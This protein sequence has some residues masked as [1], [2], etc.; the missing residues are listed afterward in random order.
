MV[1]NKN[2]DAGQRRP[3]TLR[4]RARRQEEVH[5][6]ITKITVDLHE[7]VGPAR[8]TVSEIAKRAGV[9]RATVYNHFPTELELFDACSSHWVEEHPPPNP[10]EWVGI[11]DPGR[12]LETALAALYSYYEEGQDMLENVLRDAPLMPALEE[13]NRRKWWPFI[14]ELVELLTQGWE[15]TEVSDPIAQPGP[16]NVRTSGQHANRPERTLLEASLRVAVDF[17]TWKKL[18]RAGLSNDEASR[19]ATLWIRAC[20]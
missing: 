14:E 3:Y 17:F 2:E 18:A 13:I 8:T 5:R 4:E 11:E 9:Q 6:R 12:R 16:D 7:T 10:A 20:V 15:D 19:L 1:S